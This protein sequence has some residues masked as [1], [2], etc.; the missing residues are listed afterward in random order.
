MVGVENWTISLSTGARQ[1]PLA[2]WGVLGCCAVPANME[3]G[4]GAEKLSGEG[5]FDRDLSGEGEFDRDE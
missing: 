5:E 3:S 4:G 1:T 2:P